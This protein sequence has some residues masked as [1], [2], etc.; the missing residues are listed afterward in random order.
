M[1][2]NE[3]GWNVFFL[4]RT[5]AKRHSWSAEVHDGLTYGKIQNLR[6]NKNK[7][8]NTKQANLGGLQSYS[9]QQRWTTI[10]ATAEANCAQ[11][12]AALSRSSASQ[13]LSPFQKD[14]IPSV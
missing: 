4:D 6:S 1:L 7:D 8:Q 3:I 11:K 14:C 9:F 12:A 10:G 2:K 5:S 13:V